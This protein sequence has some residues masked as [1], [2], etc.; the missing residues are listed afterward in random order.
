M[1][2]CHATRKLRQFSQL[3]PI[4]EDVP[5]PGHCPARFAFGPCTKECSE[6][7]ECPGANKCCDTGCGSVCSTPLLAPTAAARSCRAPSSE[8]IC[9][10]GT[11]FY[12]KCNKC[13]CGGEDEP[14]RCETNICTEEKPG[15]CP[16]KA[17][18]SKLRGRS[19]GPKCYGD[20]D[21]PRDS[22]CCDITGCGPICAPPA[23]DRPGICPAAEGH[24]R[25]GDFCATDSDCPR[26]SKCCLTG[27]GKMCKV[28]DE[29]G[30]CPAVT[31][32]PNCFYRDNQCMTS[33]D[34]GAGQK[35]CD[36][37]CGKKCSEPV[38]EKPGLCPNPEQLTLAEGIFCKNDHQCSQN[39]KCCGN[40][41][42]DQGC[43]QP[44]EYRTTCRNVRCTKRGYY[45]VD[46][47]HGPECVNS[48]YARGIALTR[49]PFVSAHQGGH[50]PLIATALRPCKTPRVLCEG[51]DDCEGGNICCT[52]GCVRKCVK[53]LRT[54]CASIG[55]SLCR[56]AGY[57]C[58]DTPKGAVCVEDAASCEH[59]HCPVGYICHDQFTS[60]ARCVREVKAG[61]CPAIQPGSYRGDCKDTCKYD[62]ECPKQQ[63]CCNNGCANA[64]LDPD[65]RKS[66]DDV[67]CPDGYACLDKDKLKD[68]FC[69]N[70]TQ[71]DGRCPAADFW[72]PRTRSCED[73]CVYD[74][75][76]SASAHRPTCVKRCEDRDCEEGYSCVDDGVSDAQCV[77]TA[78]RPGRCPVVAPRVRCP[79]DSSD[80]CEYDEQ[81]PEG[82]RC[83]NADGCGNRCM[84]ADLR[85]LCADLTCSEG[86]ACVGSIAGDAQCL[87]TA[88][89]PGLCPRVSSDTLPRGGCRSSCQY[90]SQCLNDSK[91]CSNGCASVCR[92]PRAPDCDTIKCRV[93]F[94][95]T[96]DREGKPSCTA[97]PCKQDGDIIDIECNSCTCINKFLLC[98]QEECP[99]VKP[100]FCPKLTKGYKGKCVEECTSDY[101]CE[102]DSKCCNTGCGHTCQNSVPEVVHPCRTVRFRCGD[103]TRCAATRG[104]C[105][106]GKTCPLSPLCVSRTAPF[107]ES[108]PPGKVCVL[109]KQACPSGG[110]YRQP[111]CVQL[112]SDDTIFEEDEELE[113]AVVAKQNP[114][115]FF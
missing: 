65:F 99:P 60:G 107:C 36:S 59:K 15:F 6:D 58:Q 79:A 94:R 82:L 10:K 14:V 109:Q 113:L 62:S 55:H 4:G 8:H 7:G 49:V 66:C 23:E 57:T 114:K 38:D 48:E 72:N 41:K 56:T 17:L 37:P 92:R 88:E 53:P 40:N 54:D 70:T 75:Q 83:C 24:D 52:A 102:S 43:T 67:N 13:T 34:C 39:L 101:N 104:L 3:A 81:C 45:C 110:C 26:S 27:C 74:F 103:E 115:K 35:C 32:T 44:T 77:S 100:G 64:C 12:N 2:P 90:D 22:K 98:S 9:P 5:K 76:C 1:R 86:T 33:S 18:H 68:A 91:C 46:T 31:S 21:C 50:C 19:C 69:V 111:I 93:G 87:S 30:F 95:C 78:P 47:D 16:N 80:Q 112:Y 105:Q 51:D 97:I 106:P 28:A 108:C 73:Q 63:R 42:G 96:E 89:K 20:D 61:R 84:P 85:K 29:P 11:T 25:C 71:K